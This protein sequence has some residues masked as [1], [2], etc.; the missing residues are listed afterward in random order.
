MTEWFRQNHLERVLAFAESRAWHEDYPTNVFV[1][2]QLCDFHREMFKVFV[3]KTLLQLQERGFYCY[4]SSSD[5]SVLVTVGKDKY[6]KAYFDFSFN[7]NDIGMYINHG[8]ESIVYRLGDTNLDEIFDKIVEDVKAER[9]PCLKEY[10][11][12]KTESFLCWDSTTEMYVLDTDINKL[13]RF[14]N[15]LRAK[16]GLED[17]SKC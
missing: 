16:V 11:E 15:D 3:Q 8:K 4:L 13:N 9:E 5:S 6:V 10:I 17:L 2:R 1:S 7:T 12:N 14:L